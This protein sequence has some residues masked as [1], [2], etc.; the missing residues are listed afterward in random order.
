MLN[1]QFKAGQGTCLKNGS[2]LAS[3]LFS[4][5]GSTGIFVFHK[6][7]LSSDKELRLINRF[8]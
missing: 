3:R 4:N 6:I 5:L 7:K 1:L 8:S 2:I